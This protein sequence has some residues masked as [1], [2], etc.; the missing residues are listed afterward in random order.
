VLPSSG[1]K[2][3]TGRATG[4]FETSVI[5]TLNGVTT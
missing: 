1:Y 4:S 3:R 2:M 5:I